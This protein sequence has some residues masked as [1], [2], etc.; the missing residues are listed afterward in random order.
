MNGGEHAVTELAEAI[1]EALTAQNLS[2]AVAESL[3]GGM[4]LT[5]LT[6]IPGA[7]RCVRGGVVAY[8][9]ELKRDLLT[10]PGSLLDS[11]GPVHPGVAMSMARGVRRL[12]AIDG[13]AADI[14]V[15]T[16]GVA[17]PD[18]QG[19]HSPGTVYIAFAGCDED[20]FSAAIGATRDVT[21]FAGSRGSDAFAVS[22]ALEG[23]R[24]DIRA[25]TVFEALRVL[26]QCVSDATLSR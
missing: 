22:L 21:P 10:V 13:T 17:G 18:A 5:A 7:S 26:H 11:E 3:T 1:I 16:S 12:C 2:V 6:S 19:G 8:A 9:T 14:G 23:S 4:L 15:A 24:D 20:R 25:Q